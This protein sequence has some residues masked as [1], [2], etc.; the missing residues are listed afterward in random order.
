MGALQDFWVKAGQRHL[1]TQ[2]RGGIVGPLDGSIETGVRRAL[3]SSAM[4]GSMNAMEWGVTVA[5]QLSRQEAV[6]QPILIEGA[7]Y[8]SC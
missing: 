1:G 8:G 5:P 2:Q 3:E 6:R 7:Y 4:R